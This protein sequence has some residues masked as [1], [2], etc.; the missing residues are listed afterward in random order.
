MT[1]RLFTFTIWRMKI[2]TSIAP[3]IAVVLCT[4]PLAL[5]AG[6][7]VSFD[8]QG[9]I[10]VN[11]KPFFPIGIWVY[12]I[13]GSVMHECNERRFNTIVGNGF[14]P[15]AM[16]QIASQG[17]MAIPFSTPEFLKNSIEHP[18]LLLWYLVDEPEGAGSH[19][20]ELVK[21]AYA[22]LKEKD[23]NHP[24]GVDMFLLDAI[25]K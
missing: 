3:L 17:M 4:S 5:A 7:K 9:V 24:A 6:T 1:G 20:P 13:N 2:A 10:Q 16:D 18:A 25:A 8:D 19:S 11:N 14:G 12:E 22:H 21:Q 15:G 23:K